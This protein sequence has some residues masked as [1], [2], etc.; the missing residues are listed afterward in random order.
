MKLHLDRI[1]Q[2]EATLT[3]LYARIDTVLEPFS[4]ARELLMTIPGISTNVANVIIA[5]AGV[6]MK[7]FDTAGHLASWAGVCPSRNESAGRTK[8]TQTRPGDHYLRAALVI[9]TLPVS[10]SKTTYLA[11]KYRRIQS[12]T[13]APSA[14]GALQHTL[15]VIVWNRLH[16]G[17]AYEE[18]GVDHYDKT[19]PER[20]KKRLQSRMVSLG[21]EPNFIP[22]SAG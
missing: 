2:I 3:T 13:G 5:E 9:A 7:V 11:V 22:L 10:R 15:L 8:S 20:A 21:F 6:D 1:D 4:F 16:D 14:V 19:I 17:V 12:H 18:F